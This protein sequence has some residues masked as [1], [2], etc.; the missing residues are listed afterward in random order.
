VAVE[1]AS[2]GLAWLL[3][4]GSSVHVAA[5][6]WLFEAHELRAHIR[7]HRLRYLAIPLALITGAALLAVI[8]PAGVLKLLLLAFFGWQFWHFQRQ[9]YGLVAL[10]AASRKVP[11]LAVAERRAL[12]ISGWAGITGALSQPPLLQVNVSPAQPLELVA[13]VGFTL[14]VAQGLAALRRR[15]RRQR[16]GAFTVA[17]LMALFFFLPV[18]LFSSP[19]LAV[20][21]LVIAHGFQYLMLA[22]L[23]ATG[24]RRGIA[25]LATASTMLC[26]ALVAGA[27]LAAAA[28]QHE[29][30]AGGRWIYGAYLGVVMSH[31]VVDAR[32]WRLRDP[33]CR[34]FISSRVPFLLPPSASPVGDG[35][36]A[37]IQ[38]R[39]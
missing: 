11:S 32:I 16:P 20:G 15:P 31:F 28:H 30:D 13:A 26:L 6:A 7:G 8:V 14:G 4:A 34:R 21:S 23:V 18:F 39:T 22:G 5:T 33:F 38:S 9:N 10:A 12:T 35:S 24:H 25:R 1:P 29:A 3:F 37:D 36:D 2:A 17:Y 19:Y 27:I